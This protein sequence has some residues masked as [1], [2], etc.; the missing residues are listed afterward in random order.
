MRGAAVWSGLGLLLASLVVSAQPAPAPPGPVVA[1]ARLANPE[2]VRKQLGL[3]PEYRT[4]AGVEKVK[5]AILDYGFA[6]IDGIRPYLPPNTVVV[7]HYDPEF[8]RSFQLGDPEFRR[9]FAPGNHHGRLMAQLVWAVSGSHPDGPQFFLLNANGPTMLRRAIRFAIEVKVDVILFSGTFEGAGNGDGRGP[10]N[11]AVSEATAAGILWINAAGNSGGRV[12]NGPVDVRRDG[13]LRLGSGVDPTALRFRNRLDENTVTITLTWNDYRDVEDAGTTKDLNLYVEDGRGR[14]VGASELVQVA[15]DR[16]AGPGETRNPRERLVLPDLP[17][18]ELDYRIRIRA[19]AGE[20][21]ASDRIRVLV[22]ASR[23]G[24]FRDPKTKAPANAFEFP[25]AT[26]GGEIYPPADH[27]LVITVGDTSP[28][29]SVGPTADHRVKPDVILD[30]AEAFFTNGEVISGASVAAAYFAGVVVVLKA[31]EPGLEA[32]HLLALAQRH[33]AAPEPV[34]RSGDEPA[35]LGQELPLA[36]AREYHPEI[37]DTVQRAVGRRPVRAFMSPYNR[38]V[39]GIDVS[40]AD[41][42]TLFA[43]FPHDLRDL[44]D[45]YEFYLSATRLPGPVQDAVVLDAYYR[46]KTLPNRPRDPYPWE[47]TER[48][49]PGPNRLTK[50]DFVEVRRLAPHDASESTRRTT[51]RRRLWQT[52]TRQELAAAV[53]PLRNPRP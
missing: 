22:T 37:V 23:D 26:A 6:G 17:A 42:R 14:R 11:A 12:F 8:V 21:T 28:T 25:D 24:Q 4:V 41:L 29:S 1:V 50:F 10:I 7:E 48:S 32:R 38:L 33:A 35:A 2:E 49:L 53:R 46:R 9:P 13:Y 39:L 43:R 44:A 16:P 40:P 5:V 45:H 19:K 20:W 27:P 3:T 51:L 47:L 36:K 30:D 34:I 52:P 18:S 15:G 31:A